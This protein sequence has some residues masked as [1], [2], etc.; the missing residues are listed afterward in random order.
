MFYQQPYIKKLLY[1]PFIFSQMTI[2]L[3]QKLITLYNSSQGLSFWWRISIDTMKYIVVEQPM[4]M[5]R[6][7]EFVKEQRWLYLYNE[8]TCLHQVMV[9]ILQNVILCDLHHVL[10]LLLECSWHMQKQ[11]RP[12]NPRNAWF[13]SW[14]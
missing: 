9:H 3:N 14:L 4:K 13:Q 10:E 12:H 5:D 6:K 1:A 7:I 11:P 2:L 8:K